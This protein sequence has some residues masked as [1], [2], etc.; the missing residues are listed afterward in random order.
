MQKHDNIMDGR[1]EL[2]WAVLACILLPLTVYFNSLNAPFLF[3]DYSAIVDNPDIRN[4]GFLKE[5]LIYPNPQETYAQRNNPSRLFTYLTFTLN[6]H[7][8]GLNAV[9]YRLTNLLILILSTILVFFLTRTITYYTFK[10]YHTVIP[11]SVALFFASHPVQTEA[12]TYLAH[13]TGSLSSLFYLTTLLLFFRGFERGRVYYYL[14]LF[15][16]VLSLLSKEIGITLPMTV[17][18][19]DYLFLSDLKADKLIEK[20]YYHLP[21]WLLGIAYV[22]FIVVIKR[23]V[24]DPFQQT[25]NDHTAYTYFITQIFVVLKYLKVLV[26]PL[27]QCIDHYIEGARTIL[28]PRV[29]LAIA[30]WLVLFSIGYWAV[31][32]HSEYKKL[33]WFATILFFVVL[34]PTSS[35]VPTIEMADR[36][37]YLPS[38]GFSIALVS[39][40]ALVFRIDLRKTLPSERLSTPFVIMSIHILLLSG[41]TWKRNGMYQNPELLWEEAIREYPKNHRAYNNLGKVFSRRGERLKALPFFKKAISL[42]PSYYMAYK[43][44]ADV[45]YYNK[46]LDTAAKYY[47]KTIEIMPSYDEPYNNLGAIYFQ[48]KE[49]ERAKELFQKTVAVN[50]N[51]SEGYNNLGLVCK[52]EKDYEGAVEH[53]LKAIQIN[54]LHVAARTNLGTSFYLLGEYEKALREYEILSRMKPE[55]RKVREVV[56]MLREKT[57]KRDF[58]PPY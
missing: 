6:Y 15:S 38:W 58:P 9:G 23:G 33:F 46:E 4:I 55:D 5:R 28:D 30:V 31:K 16:F 24:G 47:V 12:I 43:N 25:F 17:L 40:Y 1:K 13:R 37:L 36:R 50:P 8:G 39:I 10:R 26:M 34:I 21:Y 18:V 41:M 7:F 2:L 45:F 49:F 57:G 35:I 32:K 48:K 56:R 22:V 3:D 27:G 20:K 11:L 54:P 29:M 14:S 42:D 53:Y 19:M 51:S 52:E 44:T